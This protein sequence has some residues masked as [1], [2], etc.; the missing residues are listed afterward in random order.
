L[1]GLEFRVPDEFLQDRGIGV[2]TNGDGDA[3]G[4]FAPRL[5][6]QGGLPVRRRGVW[7]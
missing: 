4:F 5:I 7:L 6:Q 1:Q 2:F 3:N